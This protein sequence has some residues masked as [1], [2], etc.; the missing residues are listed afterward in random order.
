VIDGAL[1]ADRSV[2]NVGAGTGSYE[3]R[4]RPVIA[5]EP[6][7]VMLAQRPTDAA[8]A[9]QGRAEALPF[10][11]STFDVALAVLTIHHWTDPGAGLAELRRVARRQLVVTWDHEVAAAFWLVREYVPEIVEYDRQ[12]PTLDTV[13]RHLDVIEVVDLPVPA[14][15]ADGVMAAYWRRPE[16]YLDPGVRANISGLSLL[17]PDVI[18]RVA[19]RLQSDLRD[20]TWSARHHELLDRETFDAGYRLA[21]ARS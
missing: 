15:C 21:V 2:V 11:D 10:A 19:D 13:R 14:A 9:V 17:E 8:P 7:S 20:G 12:A 3:P 6:S 18:A 1:G 16:A 5:L 4:D